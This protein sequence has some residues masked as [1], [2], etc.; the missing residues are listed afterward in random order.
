MRLSRWIIYA[1]IG[2][3]LLFSFKTISV[4]YDTQSVL[5]SG[6]WLFAGSYCLLN[7]Y[8]LTKTHGL[9][10]TVML[11][12]NLGI[13][14]AF[15]QRLVFLSLDY[16]SFE[17]HNFPIPS[18]GTAL[19]ALV[20][21]MMGTLAFW[22]GVNRGTRE[23]S[24][25]V[26]TLGVRTHPPQESLLF[27][28]RHVL[29]SLGLAVAFAKYYF[30]IS[31]GLSLP[32]TTSSFAFLTRLLPSQGMGLLL[33]Y[34]LVRYWEHLT[35][36][37]KASLSSFFFVTLLIELGVGQRGALLHPIIQWLIVAVWIYGNLRISVRLVVAFSIVFLIVYPPFLGL[38]MT[39][40][41]AV[42][43]GQTASDITLFSLDSVSKFRVQGTLE[44]FSK[45]LYGFDMLV[46]IMDYQPTWLRSYMTPLNFTKSV[47]GM[48]LPRNIWTSSIPS[49]G[50]LA[51]V[52]GGLDWDVRNSGAWFAF[53]AMYGYFGWLGIVMF[54]VGGRLL[55]RVLAYLAGSGAF[56][57]F[58]AV[59][60]LS[61]LVWSFMISG[62]LDLLLS[63]FVSDALITA[64][65]VWTLLVS[66]RRSYIR[67]KE[68]HPSDEETALLPRWL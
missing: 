62:N 64:G 56:A 23:L 16:G 51:S 26:T 20:F 41:G 43:S 15:I 22:L 29:A 61:N 8:L 33:M 65:L 54:G 49:L 48:L 27:R 57:H 28:Q 9:S 6:V 39:V 25:N 21:M 19:K 4:L 66:D 55:R 68:Q 63:R 36:G 53:G 18:D 24:R 5:G 40:R 58:I 3:A 45:R 50:K 67:G 7:A 30:G 46:A 12:V 11:I 32:T 14:L 37:D 2:I 60:I 17:H 10:L 38:I 34:I 42:Y 1:Y 52:Y 47:M 59:F 13:L 35:L 31:G 44:F